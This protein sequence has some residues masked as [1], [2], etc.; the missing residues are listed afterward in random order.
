MSSSSPTADT[1]PASTG[2]C[3]AGKATAGADVHAHRGDGTAPAGEAGAAPHAAQAAG[4]CHAT[5]AKPRTVPACCAP[6]P[7]PRTQPSCC[8]GDDATAPA[9]RID[10]LLATSAALIAIGYVLHLAFAA[11]DVE[12]P[13]LGR[14]AMGIHHVVNTIW[15]GV[16]LGMLM[17]GML[18]RVPREFVIGT[19]G[20]AGVGGIARATLAGVLLDLCSHGILMVA[21]KLYE[22]G[23]STGQVIAFLIASP[24]NSFSMTLILFALVGVPWTLAFIVLS[25]AIALV[26]GLVF[27]HLVAGGQLPDNPHRRDLPADFRFW[28]EAR[29]GLA[30][31]DWGPRTWLDVLRSG[32]RDS[33]MVLRWI[34]LGVVLAALIRTVF[35]AETFGT[36]FGPTL[37]GLA[38]TLLGATIIEVCS[39]GSAPIAGDLFARAGAPGNAFTFLMAGVATDYTEMLVLREVTRSWKFALF[40]PLVTLPQV[41]ALG[42][43][44][45]QVPA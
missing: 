6:A 35:D 21:S 40:L 23:A 43:L 16:L 15:W 7:A 14:Y 27:D 8:A 34:L 26:S 12:V 45:N 25:M 1:L 39:E 24:W 11:Y 22:R 41:L 42:W 3:C 44:L 30:R 31:A 18:A 38:L 32:V 37:G 5:E 33:R 9:R 28:R 17:I 19:L 4:S 2:T 10:W 13:V 29:A 20:P 36:W